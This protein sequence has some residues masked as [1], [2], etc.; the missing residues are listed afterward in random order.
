MT[1][2]VEVTVRRFECLV[3]VLVGGRSG[4]GG[5]VGVCVCE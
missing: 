4:G 3:F 5:A 1:V 2:S